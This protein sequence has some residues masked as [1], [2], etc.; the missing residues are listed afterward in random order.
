MSP[1][2]ASFGLVKG[3]N[4][5]FLIQ[6]IILM[7]F[8]LCFYKSRVSATLNFNT[9]LYQLVKVKNLEKGEAF[10]IKQKHDIFFW[11][12]GLWWNICCHNKNFLIEIDFDHDFLFIIFY[13][14]GVS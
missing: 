5:S 13:L 6:N 2:I 9:F 8:K 1:R 14:S 10:N 7:V 12:N 4:K 3:N 11:K